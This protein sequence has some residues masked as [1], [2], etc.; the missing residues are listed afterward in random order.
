MRAVVVPVDGS[1]CSLRAVRYLLGMRAEGSIPAD[2]AIHLVNVQ[3]PVSA[4]IGQFVSRDQVAGFHRDESAQALHAACAL[5]EAAGAKCTMHSEVGTVAEVVVRLASAL[6]CDHIVMGTHGRGAL[7]ELLVGSTTL[8][9]VH[10]AQV[11][12]VLVK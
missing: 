9:V 2:L 6:H 7:A 1:E 8:K 10:L 3:H 12:V 4:H 5:I 11:P